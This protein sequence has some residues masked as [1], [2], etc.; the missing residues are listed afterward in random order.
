MEY[1]NSVT[2]SMASQ[3]LLPETAIT[4]YQYHRVQNNKRKILTLNFKFL[5][6]ITKL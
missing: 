3:L 2:V 1:S 6:V 5:F 4:V